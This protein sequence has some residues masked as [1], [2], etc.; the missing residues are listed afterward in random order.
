[1]PL[2]L[3]P[4]DFS[5]AS[6]NALRYALNL[7]G[8]R[9]EYVL[10]H[11]YEDLRTANASLILLK[12]LLAE[13]SADSLAEEESYVRLDLGFGEVTLRTASEYGNPAHVI[14]GYCKDHAVDVVVMGISNPADKSIPALVMQLATCPVL[15][16]PARFDGRGPHNVFFSSEPR[17]LPQWFYNLTGLPDPVVLAS[18][19]DI[20]M[21]VTSTRQ[22]PWLETG[23]STFSHESLKEVPLLALVS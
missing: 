20:D 23:N 19:Q 22:H 21:V 7:F 6:R 1:M 13:A 2:I 16:I 3:V 10:L 8:S 4:T 15:T 11:A 18:G 9:A 12:D 14:H 5:N 17:V